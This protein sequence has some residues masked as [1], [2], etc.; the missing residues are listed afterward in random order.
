M[1]FTRCARTKWRSLVSLL[2]VIE[3]RFRFL[4]R[5]LALHVGPEKGICQGEVT[6]NETFD[7]QGLF[8]DGSLR[9]R[10]GFG[11]SSLATTHTPPPSSVCVS[12][13]DQMIGNGCF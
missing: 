11:C 9:R 12:S 13:D 5:V 2:L 10:P 8:G 6:V 3:V 4:L 1:L 7:L